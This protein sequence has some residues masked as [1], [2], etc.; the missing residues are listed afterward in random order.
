MI[1]LWNSYSQI[2]CIWGLYP[3]QGHTLHQ[4]WVR[5]GQQLVDTWLRFQ[6]MVPKWFI[7]WP[8]QVD[9]NL[10]DIP[11]VIH[12]IWWP[13]PGGIRSYDNGRRVIW[14][15]VIYGAQGPWHASLP[16]LYF[17]GDPSFYVAS[18]ELRGTGCSHSWDIRKNN[19]LEWYRRKIWEYFVSQSV[20]GG[21]LKSQLHCLLCLG[22][23]AHSSVVMGRFW[24]KHECMW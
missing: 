1:L 23:E 11:W 13:R 17:S 2:T 16:P 9:M 6:E 4:G 14:N 15:G 19:G 20:V 12:P 8:Q 18:G 21:E 5:R 7:S 3:W 24:G 22:I 10:Y